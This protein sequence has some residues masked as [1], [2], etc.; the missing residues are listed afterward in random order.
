VTLESI[1][2]DGFGETGENQNHS[3]ELWAECY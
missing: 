3:D 2:G 1:G